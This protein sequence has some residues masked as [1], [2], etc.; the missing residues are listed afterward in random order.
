MAEILSGDANP[1]GKL[2]SV[3]P[4]RWEDLPYFDRNAESIEY[5]YWHGYRK[6]ERDEIEPAFPFGFGL[7]YTDFVL[8]NFQVKVRENVSD[9]E[10]VALECIVQVKNVGRIEGDEIVQIYLSAIDSKVSPR[11]KKELIAFERV[12]MVKPGEIRDVTLHIIGERMAYYDVGKHDYVVERCRYRLIAARH[13]LDVT[14]LSAE[15]DWPSGLME[16][17]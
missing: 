15:V 16:S 6:L 8:T 12:R 4:K 10:S 11:P 14:A 3:F 7:S 2:P 5:D 13:S 1:S 17:L 9:L